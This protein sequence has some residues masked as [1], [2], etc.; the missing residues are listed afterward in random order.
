MK[1]STPR[2]TNI[3]IGRLYNL[4]SYEHVRY[5]LAVE[6]PPGAS[7]AK[8][9]AS[10]KD[11]LERLKPFRLSM[12]E[13]YYAHQNE[14]FREALKKEPNRENAASLREQIKQNTRA[15]KEYAAARKRIH[16]AE[17]D[18]DRLGGNLAYKDAKLDWDNDDND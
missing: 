4:G 8:T 5:E 12:S 14:T 6:V 15:L 10:M 16:K 3:T 17:N 13:E 9:I 18:L 1:K 2:V 11:V 7:A